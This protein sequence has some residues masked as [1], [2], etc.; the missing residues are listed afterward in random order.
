MSTIDQ[1]PTT[2]RPDPTADQGHGEDLGADLIETVIRPRSGWVALD[3]A[4][5]SRGR[6]LL[7]Y[8]IWRDVKIRYKQTVLGIA[9]AVLQPLF[10]MVVF[11]LI[12][13]RIANLETSTAGVPYP[14]F[15]FIGLIF[16]AYF[17]GGVTT[18]GMSLVSQQHLVTKVYFPRLFVPMACI[19][20]LL[21][22]LVI[23]LG[24][25]A[26]LM[27]FFGVAPS[28]QTPLVVPLIGLMTLASLGLGCL[29]AALTV[30]YRDVRYVVGFAMQIMM[31]LSPVIYPPDLLP[32]A[33][34]PILALNPMFGLIDGSRSAVLGT[35]WHFRLLA[36]SST[37]SLALFAFGLYYFRKTERRFADLV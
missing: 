7:Y 30:V 25:F 2:L 6:E 20:T 11:S 9:W 35:D 24:V 13:G 14:I 32:K 8:F 21:V 5:M 1:L 15:V 22:D 16:W 28:W 19:G 34:H 37:S 26:V 27:I 4:E 18:A 29:C 17:S 33:Y 36:I 31:Y 12:F 23:S 10:T 3:W